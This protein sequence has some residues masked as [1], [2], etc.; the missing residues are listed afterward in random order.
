VIS[1]SQKPLPDNTQHSPQTDIHA[2]GGIRT[3]D[4]S[5]RA[6]ADL[7]LRPRG[8]WD[9]QDIMYICKLLCRSLCIYASCCNYIVLITEFLMTAYLTYVIFTPEYTHTLTRCIFRHHGALC[10]YSAAILTQALDLNRYMFRRHSA[11]YRD[12]IKQTTAIAMPLLHHQ[13]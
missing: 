10:R 6:A 13:Q 8:H 5:R 11:I 7:P 2:P 9:W 12:S 1:S 4:L 3:H